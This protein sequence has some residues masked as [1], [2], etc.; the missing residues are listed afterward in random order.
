M[1]TII[2]IIHQTRCTQSKIEIFQ[3]SCDVS[4]I[5]AQ[6]KVNIDA[7]ADNGEVE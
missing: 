1:I 4:A 3:N 6:Y 7:A 5:N 2:F